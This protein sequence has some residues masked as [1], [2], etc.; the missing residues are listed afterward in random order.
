MFLKFIQVYLTNPVGCGLGYG[1]KPFYDKVLPLNNISARL[2]FG[3]LPILKASWKNEIQKQR[4]SYYV[5]PLRLA[6]PVQHSI[7]FYRTLSTD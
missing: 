5:G 7:L 2:F 1:S 4:E 3:V 6:L